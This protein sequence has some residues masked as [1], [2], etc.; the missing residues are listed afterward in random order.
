MHQL[1]HTLARY[2]A[3][4]VLYPRSAPGFATG[5]SGGS[6]PSL[7]VLRSRR[8]ICDRF[9]RASARPYGTIRD[10]STGHRIA[11]IAPYGMPVLASAPYT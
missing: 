11:S 10:V 2:R 9:F 1:Y 4:V 3:S 8:V 6:A 5:H 7:L